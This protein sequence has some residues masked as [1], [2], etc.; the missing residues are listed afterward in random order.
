VGAGFGFVVTFQSIAPATTAV[1]IEAVEEGEYR[2]GTW[3]PGRRLNGDE[4]G[5]G[6]VWRFP[7]GDR[8]AF[9][10]MPATRL[11][12]PIAHCTVYDYA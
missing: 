12:A 9:G 10:P 1:G 6:K 7:A 11:G 2:G 5:S 8:P 3:V 4:T